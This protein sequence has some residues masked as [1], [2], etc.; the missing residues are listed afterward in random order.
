M[1]AEGSEA[2]VILLPCLCFQLTILK[3][4]RVDIH[5]YMLCYRYEALAASHLDAESFG[6]YMATGAQKNARGNVLFFEIDRNLE[7][8]YFRLENIEER[9]KP[10]LNGAPKRSKYISIY[11]VLEH[12]ELPAFGKL[13]LTTADGRILALESSSYDVASDTAGPKLYDEL[14]PVSP[15][16]VS[17]LGP[18]AFSHF[19]TDPKNP[20]SVPRIFFADMLMDRD[21]TGALAGYLPYSDPVHIVDC[22]KELESNP[23]KPTKT[24]SRVSRFHSFFRTVGRGFY[25]GDQKG[26]KFYRFPDRRELE[27]EHARWW[28]SASESLLS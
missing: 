23:D 13:Y 10:H 19:M 28:R 22:I 1:I 14:C 26:I 16:V 9:C 11:R 27:V 20:V 21:D 17:T 6:R 8:T 18:A 15:M 4:H 2:R 3:V 12:L 25:L 24:V 5:Y 7:S